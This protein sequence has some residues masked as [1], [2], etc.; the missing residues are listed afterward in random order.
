M[1]KGKVR[2]CGR[3][4]SEGV[5]RLNINE[6]TALWNE[7]P[8]VVKDVRRVRTDAAQPRNVYRM[9]ANGFLYVTE[10]SARLRIDAAEYQAETFHVLHAGRGMKLSIVPTD[11]S[12]QLE[13]YLIL[14]R[15][16]PSGGGKRLSLSAGQ[17]AVQYGMRAASPLSLRQYAEEMKQGWDSGDELRRYGVR[18]LFMQ[19][20][21]EVL[22]QLHGGEGSSFL[23]DPV[24]QAVRYIDEHYDRPFTIDSLAGMLGCSPRHLNRLFRKSGLGSNPSGYL[25]NVRMEKARELL[26]REQ[27]TVVEIAARVG[28]EDAYHFSRVFKKH[29][30][31]SPTAYRKREGS[32]IPPFGLSDSSIVPASADLYIDNYSQIKDSD[33]G[34]ANMSGYSGKSAVWMLLLSLSLLLAACSPPAGSGTSASAGTERSSEQPAVSAEG[35]RTIKH[36]IGSTDIQGVP[37]RI[38]VLEQ[39]FTQTVAA[40]EVKPVGVADDNKPERFPQDTLAYIEGY[41][42]VGTRSEPNLEIIRTLKPDLIIADTSRH[43]NVYEEL[44]AIAPTI[45]FGNDTAN[46]GQI[47]AST[48]SIGQAIGREA[49]VEKMLADHAAAMDDLKSNIEPGQSVLI[50]APDEE[51]GQSFQVRTDSAFHPSFLTEAGLNYALEDDTQV[52]QLMTTEQL[53]ALD[54]QHLLILI[55]EDEG[56]VLEAQQANPLWNQLQAVA[57]GHAHEVQLATWSRQRSIPA[58]NGIMDEAAELF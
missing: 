18:A 22:R 39:G 19:F 9:P 27:W 2:L 11:A 17:F 16:E 12:T 49:E 43:T 24:Q 45:V 42:S 13:Y 40:L 8:I 33:G 30:G 55:N 21:Y 51:D 26:L 35:T 58:L 25:L 3:R 7:M 28:Y 46:Y 15:P 36:D 1:K 31:L 20:V 34:V 6:Y 47:L 53:L 56:S 54:P 52:S 32:P 48:R 41:T 5:K 57:G 14:Y 29:G 37:Q 50:V 10:G 4:T 38:V 23:A 44:T